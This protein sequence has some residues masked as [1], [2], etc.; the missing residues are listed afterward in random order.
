VALYHDGKRYRTFS[1]YLQQLF[2]CRVHKVSLDAGF[3]CPNRDGT[4]GIGGCIFCNNEGFSYNTARSTP[5]LIRQLEEGMDYM[6]RR[7]GAGKF[8]AYF[9]AYSSTYDNPPLLRQAY[10]TITAYP[11]IVGLFISTRPDCVP[12]EVLD[13]IAGYR[14]RY[15]TW[16]ELGLQTADE[17]TLQHLNR[18][19][20]VEEFSDAVSRAARRNIP[21]FA[22]VILGLPGETRK[23]VLATADF[24]AR[25]R[26]QGV[27]VHA[28]H[29][30]R[31]TPLAESWA[32]EPFDLLTL[33]EYAG[34]ACDFLERIPPD[35]V[36]QRI[37]VDVPRRLL[38]APEWCAAKQR[39][40]A[41]VER[42][43]ER[44]DSRQGLLSGETF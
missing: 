41:A 44:R 25:Q 34:L 26:V 30:L 6:R 13:L 22:H 4:R 27:K 7:F 17:A 11:E 32:R 16:L 35:V 2:G 23:Q 43:L 42:E 40:V 31:N 9:Q 14:D 24:L 39:T 8:I 36:V 5:P 21:V 3:T 10:D 33:E 15:L 18:G 37:G 20:T 1:G 28:L 38:V 12:E 19:H 29:I